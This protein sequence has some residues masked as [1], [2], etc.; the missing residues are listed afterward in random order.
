[1]VESQRSGV[2]KA[3]R[4]R[5]GVSKWAY[6]VGVVAVVVV[7]A[8]VAALLVGGRTEDTLITLRD[9]ASISIPRGAISPDAS[10]TA[11][12][13]DPET[14]PEA[15]EGFTVE[16]LYEFSVDEPLIKPVTLRFP[17][18]S[19]AR[20]FSALVSQIRRDR[21]ELAWSRV[22]NRGWL[23]SGTDRHPQYLRHDKRDMG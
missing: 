20:R 22:H 7:I 6:M 3:G 2:T 18:P 16:S 23:C 17:L 11:A 8:V 21:G 19:V 15:P 10:V 12:T 14:G 4:R 13:L 9:G 5:R 1:M